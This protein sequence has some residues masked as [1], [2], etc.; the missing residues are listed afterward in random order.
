MQTTI[1]AQRVEQGLRAMAA[2]MHS[3]GHLSHHLT[4]GAPPQPGSVSAAIPTLVRE[5]AERHGVSPAGP[6]GVDPAAAAEAMFELAD[7]MRTEL[8]AALG[9]DLGD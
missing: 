7:R 1:P 9:R 2:A 8:G 4:E 6:E 3:A 5:V